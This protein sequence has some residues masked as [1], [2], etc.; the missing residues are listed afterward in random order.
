MH[1]QAAASL[2]PTIRRQLSLFPLP[3]REL[4]TNVATL[5][6]L[7]SWPTPNPPSNRR[8]V[9]I[10]GVALNTSNL[11]STD[12]SPHP[13]IYTQPPRAH[14]LIDAYLTCGD[15]LFDTTGRSDRDAVRQA[16]TESRGRTPTWVCVERRRH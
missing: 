9:T 16:E 4:V 12:G 15:G 13:D 14:R 3:E 8:R 11:L 2:K 7:L 10:S 6:P 5:P 1:P